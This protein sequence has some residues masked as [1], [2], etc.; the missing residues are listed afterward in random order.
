M[1]TGG[2][3]TNLNNHL[4][5]CLK[6]PGRNTSDHKQSELTF[7]KIGSED[8]NSTFSTWKF[9]E[10][11]IR[12]A[13][14]HM[15]IVDELPF[16]IVEGDGFKSFLSVACPRF[17]FPSRFTIRRDCLNLFNSMKKVMKN[18]FGKDATSRI[19][20]TTDTWTSLQRV[21]Y[22]VLTAH[23]IDDEWIVGIEYLR[24]KLSHRNTCIANGK[25][26]HTRCVAH[27]LNLIVQEGV[28]Y[29]FVSVDR[30]RATVRYIRTSPLRMKKFYNRAEEEMID[31]SAH[32]CSALEPS[33]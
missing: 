11:A 15:I 6:K 16:R 31:T 14:I 10:Y 3:T 33:L 7:S 22:M 18:S 20:L 2:S 27:V 13:L 12:K 9:D 26:M 23:W 32:S 30:V 17:H 5:T 25:Y 28:K 21:S 1:E 4:K 19:C 29:S 24:K 8:A